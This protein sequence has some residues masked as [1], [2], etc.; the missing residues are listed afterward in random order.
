[1]W[2][3]NYKYQNR[4]FSIVIWK[5]NKCKVWNTVDNSKLQTKFTP[6]D[7]NAP[8]YRTLSKALESLQNP[9][10]LPYTPYE[11]I[12]QHSYLIV[13]KMQELTPGKTYS[14]VAI[15]NGFMDST[16]KINTINGRFCS[17]G[18]ISS[19]ILT[20]I[21]RMPSINGVEGLHKIAVIQMS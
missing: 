16:D 12:Y 6:N 11:D 14:I 13:K 18:G 19:Y 10:G 7:A 1:M 20:T 3:N 4:N 15:Q 8:L 2:I 5:D 17:V 9:I 21:N